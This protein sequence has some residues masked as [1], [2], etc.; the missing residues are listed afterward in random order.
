M[1]SKRKRKKKAYR[2]L[3]S[4]ILFILLAAAGWYLNELGLLPEFETGEVGNSDATS[5]AQLDEIPEYSGQ[6]YCVINGNKP[7][8]EESE[9]TT[10]AFEEFSALDSLGR[11]GVVMACVGEELMPTEGRES[12]SHVKP[13]GWVNVP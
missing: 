11:C 6:A 2:S 10:E 9:I 3:L 12:I 1:S 4:F 13:S 7:F 5:A 8:F